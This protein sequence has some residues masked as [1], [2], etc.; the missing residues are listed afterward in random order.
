[1]EPALGSISK[2]YLVIFSLFHWIL[3]TTGGGL[4]DQS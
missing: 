4:E 1:M 2:P 3:P